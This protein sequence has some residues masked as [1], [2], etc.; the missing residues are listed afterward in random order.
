[1]P[2]YKNERI[3]LYFFFFAITVAIYG[4]T[5]KAGFTTDFMGW[6][7]N[8][9]NYSFSEVINSEPNHIKS[10]YQFTHLLM[11]G[12]TFLF[13]L[14]GLPWFILFSGLFAFNAYSVFMIFNKIMENVGF[15]KNRVVPLFGVLFFILSPYQAEVMVWRASFH[16][17]TGFAMMLSVVRLALAYTENPKPKYIYWA[18]IIFVCS[19]F[20]LEYFLFTPFVVL[21]FLGFSWLMKT[22]QLTNKPTNQ[23]TNKLKY[24]VGIPLAFDALYFSVHHAITGKWFAHGRDATNLHLLSVHSFSTYGKY[25]VKELLF[26]RYLKVE[27]KEK[28]F[29]FID[30]PYIGWFI[31]FIGLSIIVRGVFNFTKISAHLKLLFLNLALFSLLLVPVFSIFFSWILLS[32]NDRYCY[33]PSA[34]LFMAFAIALSRLPKIIFYAVSIA[35]FLLSSYLLIKTNRIWQQSE[36]IVSNISKSFNY[37]ETEE[38]YI[39]NAPDNYSGIPM[40]R[41]NND[42]SGV[43]EAAEVYQKRKFKGR[44]FD[45]LQY[46]MT[47][48][49]DGVS[50]QKISQDTIKVTLNQ[51]GNWWWKYGIGCGDYE[52]ADYKVKIDNDCGR[53]YTLIMKNRK[54]GRVFLYQTGNELK[55]II[56]PD[57]K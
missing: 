48:P 40:F 36:K 12:M 18:I 19:C 20:S 41:M 9:D 22:N 54:L 50:V 25:F 16:Y 8:F 31:L 49:T 5:Y 53:C 24:F 44:A 21:I 23:L 26:V 27:T 11:Y 28:I 57:T 14:S 42:T 4:I 1:M 33:I 3:Q 37:W 10:F 47:S 6:L 45:V 2:F 15:E 35:Y 38:V 30:T 51:W 17:L 13:R 43:V 29:A 52:T 55:E 39:L 7:H 56:I 34:F 46:N 32:E